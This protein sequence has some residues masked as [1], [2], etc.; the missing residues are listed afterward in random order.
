MINLAKTPANADWKSK[1]QKPS[2][3]TS[4][5]VARGLESTFQAAD[6]PVA[7][8]ATPEERPTSPEQKSRLQSEDAT[9]PDLSTSSL[10]SC[11]E[12]YNGEAYW[13]IC[14]LNH[15]QALIPPSGV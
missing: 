2:T 5:S 8:L 12:H 10:I 13:T 1:Y 11:S 7:S 4:A 6:Q 15:L 9:S 3:T 14:L